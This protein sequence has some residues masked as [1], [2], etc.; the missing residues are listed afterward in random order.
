MYQILLVRI[1]NRILIATMYLYRAENAPVLIGIV[2]F[3]VCINIPKKMWTLL[4]YLE[5]AG[6][7][8]NTEQLLYK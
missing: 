1:S 5:F 3:P 8:S 7:S 4:V 6:V 2:D